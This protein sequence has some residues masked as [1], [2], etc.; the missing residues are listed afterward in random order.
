M[1][2]RIARH[3]AERPASWRTHEAPLQLAAALVTLGSSSVIVVDC[4]TLWLTNALL[5][6][7]D[8]ANPRGPLPL[9]ER[10]R[11]ALFAFLDDFRG[12]IV[13]VSNEVGG[14]IVPESALARRFQDEQGWLNQ[15]VAQLCDRVTLAVAGLELAVKS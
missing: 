2:Q 11:D 3:R 1:E 4:L 9:W 8:G 12:T 10:E 14:G 13:L 15:R 7:F 6:D 5:P